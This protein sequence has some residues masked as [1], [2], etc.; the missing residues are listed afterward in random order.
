MVLLLLLLAVF[1]GMS[2]RRKLQPLIAREENLFLP[3]VGQKLL[4]ASTRLVATMAL[5]VLLFVASLLMVWLV[6]GGR[7]FFVVLAIAL[8]GLTAYNF[9]K[10][11][12]Q[13]LFMPWDPQQRLIAC[14]NGVAS[15][16]YSHLHRISM[17]VTVF[18]TVI[19]TLRAVNYHEGLLA[20]MNVLFYL[21]LLVLLILLTSNKEA[22]LGLLP[23]AQNRVE[24]IIYVAATQVYP[25]FI[26]L[27]ICII[28]LQGPG[29]YQPSP[30]LLTAS[31]LTAVILTA[32][33]LPAKSWTNF[34]A[35]GYSPRAVRK[36]IIFSAVRQRRRSTRFS[37][38]RSVISPILSPL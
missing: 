21:G 15:Y 22:I 32:A 18:L 38:T 20:L 6:A 34:C 9:L 2:L 27:A 7:K 16:L 1:S 25:L 37:A 36:G 23:N 17:Y 8:G 11:I 26:L 3:S 19:V 12:A 13:E 10:G 5:P 35:G 30:F 31:L 28:A 29:L 4:R 33:H 24:K 14:R